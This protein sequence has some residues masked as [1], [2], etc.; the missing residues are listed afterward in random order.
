MGSNKEIIDKAIESACDL[1]NI[2][3][4]IIY[5]V[6]NFKRELE[7]QGLMTKKLEDFIDSYLRWDN[8]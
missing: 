1:E 3:D 4:E 7:K 6:N 5:N 2:D 8:N